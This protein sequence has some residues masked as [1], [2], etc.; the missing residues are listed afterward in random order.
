MIKNL[1]L[2]LLLISFLNYQKC[3]SKDY[4]HT[5]QGRVID[6]MTGLG[7][8]SV[9]ITLMNNDSTIITTGM[10]WPK[11]MGSHV[12]TYQFHI[13]KVGK[14]IIKA[15][16]EGYDTG[17]MN[18]EL[19]SQREGYIPVRT[20]RLTKVSHI[21]D[22]VTIRAT[23]VKMVVRGD[24]IVYNADA[25]NLAEGSM[26][27]ALISRL[28]GTQLTSD[29]RI[30][31]NGKF[32]QS[33]LVNGRDFFAG[34]PKIALENLPAY[35]VNKV[36]VY[37]KEGQLSRMM[38]KKMGDETYVMDVNLKKEYST[39]Y[40][41]NTE[42][43]AGS[44]SRFIGKLFGMKMNDVERIGAFANV[45]NLNDNQ[46]A[47]LDGNWDSTEDP[48]GV[49]TTRNA[50][51]NY[52]HYLGEDDWSWIRSANVVTHTD[53]EDLSHTN[54]QTYFPDGDSYMKGKN[55]LKNKKITW[56]S[57]NAYS[58]DESG[59]YMRGH[60]NFYYAHNQGWGN[61]LQETSD[62]S[63]I[64]NSVLNR[65]D[66]NSKQLTL[67]FSHS[68]GKRIIAD[69]IRWEASAAY[70]RQKTENFS[71]HDVQYMNSTTPRDYINNYLDNAS[72]QWK[73]HGNLSYSLGWPHQDIMLDYDYHYIYNKTDNMLYR[74]DKLTDIDSTF[75]TLL[76]S[77]REALAG[78]MDRNNSY[79]YREYQNHHQFLLKFDREDIGHFLY[80]ILFRLPVRLAR[81][82]LYYNRIGRHT[83]LKHAVFLEPYLYARGTVFEH[84][85]ELEASA[86]SRMPDLTLMVDYRDD[87]NPLDIRLGN[88]NLKN[89]HRYDA[90]LSLRR[91][92]K[93][94]RMTSF[95]MGYHR[96]DNAVAYGLS[97]D[98]ETGVFTS[99]PISVD[100][101]WNANMEWGHT[102]ALD[103]TQKWT[104]DNK[105]NL[106]Y[107]H[108]VD[109]VLA[110]GSMQ[111]QR[112]IVH[113][114][115]WGDDIRL[116]FRPNDDYEFS[117]H[118][119][120]KYYFVSSRREGFKNIHAGEY[121]AGVN[122]TISLPAH[123]QL[124]TDMT[125]YARRGYQQA[126]MNTTDWI[127]NAQITR[128]FLKGQLLAKLQG[129][130]LLHQLTNTRY[131]MN[132]QGRSE[133]WHNSIPR[134]V[135]FSLAWRFSKYPK[136]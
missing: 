65:N 133:T 88:P 132:E 126:A 128:T 16:R 99:K 87:S 55:Q 136:K 20:I 19:R 36:K 53:R 40:M 127:W 15:E 3:Y 4:D 90:T 17:Y 68:G 6:N 80:R 73:L 125:M 52:I 31:V 63:M 32:I 104:I 47:G 98:K 109:M 78:V 72:H 115:Q 119:G 110:S 51:L 66:D 2:T 39:G 83:V 21:L 13:T 14:Y 18:C 42:A 26:L 34:N 24:T 129:F 122:A 74:L 70:E 8:D 79:Q 23:K 33:L 76:P 38:G 27:D 96:Q 82:N 57:R 101:N 84:Q 108:S 44:K 67:S 93:R 121:N 43:G 58:I 86:S 28:P 117:L 35:T 7:M 114:Q 113:N 9:R 135:M 62:T 94:Q 77:A 12:G 61:S 5:V 97:V 41:A 106:N 120:G 81:Q 10:T 37:H 50:G 103:S 64:L 30:Y 22:E 95:N 11:E 49:Q 54:V 46:R 29:G 123:F 118:A 85:W 89:I 124:T 130:D 25:F 92:G 56:N 75:F 48:T 112:S 134:Y 100:G 45:N 107:Q 111:S 69:F 1:C 105:F 71:L 59:Y 131:V 60:L 102:Q 116:N 91:E